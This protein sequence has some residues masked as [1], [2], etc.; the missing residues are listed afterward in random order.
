V[1]GLGGWG[2]G[3]WVRG[4]SC[5]TQFKAQGPSRT[6]N[7]S[8]EEEEVRD[9]G[10]LAWSVVEVSVAPPRPF[11]GGATGRPSRM[12]LP[13]ALPLSGDGERPGVGEDGEGRRPARRAFRVRASV[14][15]TRGQLVFKA[16]RLLY[17]ST[18]GSRVIKKKKKTRGQALS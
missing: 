5:I 16:H 14:D 13:P 10:S 11:R 12:A 17:H 3:L 9:Q 18:L 15:C 1:E 8:K 4:L 6:C 7:E 2:Q